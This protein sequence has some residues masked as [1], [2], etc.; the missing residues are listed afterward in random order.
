MAQVD[1]AFH[2]NSRISYMLVQPYHTNHGK[3]NINAYAAGTKPAGFPDWP[4]KKMHL[5]ENVLVNN[6]QH[7]INQMQRAYIHQLLV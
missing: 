1:T 2:S 5:M 6:T 7:K 3:F 4:Y